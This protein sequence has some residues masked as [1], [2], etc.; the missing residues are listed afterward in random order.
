MPPA[1]YVELRCASAFSFLEGAS[2]PEDL[3]DRAA[4]L[5]HRALALSD[6]DGLYGI[7]RFHQAAKA[8]GIEAIVG[9]R[10]SVRSSPPGQG[11]RL[12]YP[13]S[14]A[15]GGAR[16]EAKSSEPSEV[17]RRAPAQQELLLLVESQ[18][19]YRNLSRLLTAAHAKGGKH[20]AKFVTWEELE[21][22]AGGLVGLARGDGA[23]LPEA[24]DRA[25]AALGRDRVWVDVARHL[26]RAR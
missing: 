8:A 20:D 15:S 2:N 3:V 6:R 18:R 14:A 25:R 9:A 13:A 4:E 11:D 24:L 16:S 17:N 12:E 10:V 1:D 26:D 5:G 23:L 21:A 22:H 7:P 19:G